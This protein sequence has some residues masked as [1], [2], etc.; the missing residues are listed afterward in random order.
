MNLHEKDASLKAQEVAELRKALYTL[1]HWATNGDRTGNPY[2]KPEVRNA[3]RTYNRG[4]DSLSFF[5]D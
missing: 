5:P 2:C 1:L 3:I 4:G